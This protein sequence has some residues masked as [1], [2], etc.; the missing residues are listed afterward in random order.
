MSEHLLLH[1]I[2]WN[3]LCS[4]NNSPQRKKVITTG[5]LK[6]AAAA[7]LT[8]NVS[9]LLVYFTYRDVLILPIHLGPAHNPKQG[10]WSRNS[11]SPH[12]TT[13]VNPRV[14]RYHENENTNARIVPLYTEIITKNW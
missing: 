2:W 10:S 7:D 11:V 14:L 12:D 5:S 13:T 4:R 9:R 3:F 6:K 1:I 8:L